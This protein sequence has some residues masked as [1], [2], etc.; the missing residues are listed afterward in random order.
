MHV[1]P[2]VYFYVCV[3]LG[4]EE[5]GGGLGQRRAYLVGGLLPVPL[6]PVDEEQ[7]QHAQH[8]A[9]GDAHGAAGHLCCG[10]IHCKRVPIS[11]APTTIISLCSHQSDQAHV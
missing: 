8:A 10:M 4:V 1:M 2:Y 7:G 9:D 3:P 11:T 6:L 5:G